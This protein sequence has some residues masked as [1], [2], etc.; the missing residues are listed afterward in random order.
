M[1]GFVSALKRDRTTSKLVDALSNLTASA[2]HAGA[3]L[4]ENLSGS[5]GA[6]V[7]LVKRE[8]LQRLALWL[9]P[10]LLG[11]AGAISMPRIEYADST[12]GV[13]LDAILLTAPRRGTQ[14]EEGTLG[15]RS[16]LILDRIRISSW[17]EVVL[18]IDT[19]V[20][21][22]VV[23]AT[24]EQIHGAED[25]APSPSPLASGID[26]Q[27]RT[28]QT[29]VSTRTWTRVYVE[30]VRLSAHDIAYYFLYKG[31]RFYGLRVP[32]T[33]YEDEGLLSVDVGS[34]NPNAPDATGTG[35]TVDI[36]LE[37]DTDDNSGPYGRST[38][39][40]FF[41]NSNNA[42]STPSAGPLFR[43][44]DVHVDVRALHIALTR[45]RHPILNRLLFQPLAGPSARAAAV[46]VLSG[47]ILA[48]LESLARFGDRVKERALAQQNAESSPLPE[49]SED[50]GREASSAEAWWGAFL[51][52]VGLFGSTAHEPDSLDDEEEPDGVEHEDEEEP[53]IEAHTHISAQGRVRT[54]VTQD[55]G[56]RGSDP[57]ES[58]LAVEIGPQVLSG[59]GGPYT[60]SP[61]RSPDMESAAV[62]TTEEARDAARELAE[63][64]EYTEETL[65]TGVE[66]VV[67]VR[68]EITE[69]EA[70]GEVIA[71][72]ERKRRGWRSTAFDF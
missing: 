4:R 48:A 22:P 39:F 33:S 67:Q 6:R 17:N 10:K 29:S 36:E 70:R 58:V 2:A 15:V 13:A 20:G 9:L 24:S 11:V 50:S 69:A 66:R 44:T 56:S 26:G 64:E 60:G 12:I 62:R 45:T 43:V 35:L 47:H 42:D 53:F 72:V 52:E 23:G 30:G 19:G 14:G 49:G 57:E 71:R 1:D 31:A 18:D 16:S 8:A 68:Q 63:A 34:S 27:S 51:E 41:T 38:W 32:F 65:R 54:T 3:I 59:K 40:S 37:F 7:N 46:W 5:L 55:P 25:A 21:N 28:A 61:P